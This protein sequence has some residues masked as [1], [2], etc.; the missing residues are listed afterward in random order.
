MMK[1]GVYG[2]LVALD[3]VEYPVW[4]TGFLKPLRDQERRRW[5]AFRGLQDKGVA[6]SKRNR[7]HPHWNHYGKIERRNARHDPKRLSQRVRVNSGANIF[8]NLSL[9][10]LWDAGRKFNDLEPTLDFSL[11]VG[12]NFAVLRSDDFGERVDALFANAQEAV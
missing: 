2:L 7:K 9:K 3:N 10:Q 4:E 8:S 12:E 5:I 6:A 1:E 11:C